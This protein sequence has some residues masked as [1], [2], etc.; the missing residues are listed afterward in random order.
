MMVQVPTHVLQTVQPRHVVR[1]QIV[2]MPW[3]WLWVIV[4]GMDMALNR[5]EPHLMRNLSLS[6]HVTMWLNLE[7]AELAQI[8]SIYLKV[9][10][11]AVTYL[12]QKL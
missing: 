12:I 8:T 11:A 2:R 5:Q 9:K 7:V 10:A 3:V 4:L 6:V 1:L